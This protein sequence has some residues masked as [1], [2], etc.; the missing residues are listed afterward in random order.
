MLSL[1]TE[2][3]MRLIIFALFLMP[4]VACSQPG[5][6][7]ADVDDHKLFQEFRGHVSRQVLDMNIELID[8]IERR[9]DARRHAVLSRLLAEENQQVNEYDIGYYVGILSM[10]RNQVHDY[11]GENLD[12]TG[13]LDAYYRG[14]NQGCHVAFSQ[15]ADKNKQLHT[16][17]LHMRFLQDNIAQIL[18]HDP[19]SDH[20][21]EKN[22]AH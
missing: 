7:Y 20:N 12:Q 5:R 4:F 15:C 18:A 1:D 9:I 6:A 11:V 21:I 13:G 16:V 19:L 10:S 2:Y 17:L 14:F 22:S 3:E 8:E